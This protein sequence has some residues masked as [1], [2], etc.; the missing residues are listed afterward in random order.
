MNQCSNLEEKVTRKVETVGIPKETTKDIV[1]QIVVAIVNRFKCVA[2]AF[3]TAKI[4]SRGRLIKAKK[5]S[6]R[7]PLTDYGLGEYCENLDWV[8]EVEADHIS[9][10]KH[11]KLIIEIHTFFEIK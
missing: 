1:V 8:I 6:A 10:L 2:N 11:P 4:K 9:I 3:C 5:T 7:I